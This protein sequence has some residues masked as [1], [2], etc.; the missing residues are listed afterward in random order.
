[1]RLFEIIGGSGFS[2]SYRIQIHGAFSRQVQQLTH[3]MP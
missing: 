2:M 1:L 3:T